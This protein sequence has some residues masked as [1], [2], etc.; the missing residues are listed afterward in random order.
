MRN[1]TCN[2]QGESELH[3]RWFYPLAVIEEKQRN[4]VSHSCGNYPFLI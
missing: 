4:I 3:F 1:L 2:G